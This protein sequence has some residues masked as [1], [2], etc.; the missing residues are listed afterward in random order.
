MKFQKSILFEVMTST[1]IVILYYSSAF[2]ISQYQVIDLGTLEGDRV[3]A[4]D[5]N[6]N[7]L[8]VGYT[9]GGSITKAFT[10]QNGSISKLSDDGCKAYGVNDAGLIVGSRPLIFNS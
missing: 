2:A 7:G 10:W 6:N 3:Y 9:T 8:V 1:M 4:S 5:I